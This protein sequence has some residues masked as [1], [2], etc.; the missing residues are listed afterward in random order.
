MIFHV[1]LEE[2]WQRA[3]AAG[4]YRVSSLGVSLDEEGF[5]HASFAGQVEATVQRYYADVAA[6]LV[7]LHIDEPRLG[8]P[9]RV[10]PQ[11]FPHVHGPVAVAAVVRVTRLRRNRAG[12]P[13][14]PA[15]DELTGDEPEESSL[16]DGAGAA[17]AHVHT[18]R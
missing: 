2:D 5:V 7:L 8:V 11:G 1:A 13:E 6:P 17:P 9:V 15:V 14:V 10:S 16:R 12:R 18:D 4:E 3:Q